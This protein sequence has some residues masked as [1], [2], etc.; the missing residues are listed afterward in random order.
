MSRAENRWIY[1]L[2]WSI[3]AIL[4]ILAWLILRGRVGRAFRA[5][6]DSEIAAV[7]SGVE[8]GMY[9]TL[10]F[11]ISAAFCGVAGALYVMWVDGFA[12]PAG[13]RRRPVALASRRARP[14]PVSARSGVCS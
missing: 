10:A 13:V 1:G 7:A 2:A 12:Q 14:S 3:A 9:K 5:V 11:A 4:L 8:I 6:R